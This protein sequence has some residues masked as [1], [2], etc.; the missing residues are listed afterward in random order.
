M[1]LVLLAAQTRGEEIFSTGGRICMA[2]RSGLL[3]RSGM[4]AC[5]ISVWCSEIVGWT[6]MVE[7]A[8]PV[9]AT[10]KLMAGHTELVMAARSDSTGNTRTVVVVVLQGPVNCWPM[11]SPWHSQQL[12]LALYYAL[13]R[14][15]FGPSLARS[16]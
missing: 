12:S 15:N 1:S 9:A 2:R 14:A 11:R 16:W 3:V 8:E 5:S 6:L 7:H 13:V 10:Y 4:V